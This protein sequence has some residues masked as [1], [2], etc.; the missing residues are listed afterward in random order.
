[1]NG[2][3]KFLPLVQELSRDWSSV[4]KSVFSCGESMLVFLDED[5]GGTVQLLGFRKFFSF[6]KSCSD[7][8]GAF[9]MERK[10]LLVYLFS[11]CCFSWCGSCSGKES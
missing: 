4:Y 3:H 7:G 1:M 6:C 10:F 5:P 2:V 9:R 8:A 11:F